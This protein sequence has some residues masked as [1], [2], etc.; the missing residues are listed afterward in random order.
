MTEKNISVTVKTKN[1]SLV[2]I[3]G[4]EPEEFNKRV[5][6]AINAQLHEFVLG[7]EE[8]IKP[9]A[10]TVVQNAFPEA[11]VVDAWV[12][13]AQPV[14]G[15]APIPPP[16]SAAPAPA[17]AGDR[18]CPHGVMT[19]RTGEGQYGPWKAWMCPTPKGTPD[20]CKAIYAK[21]GTPEFNNF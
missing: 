2:T 9:D 17:S 5:N 3:R 13:E 15:F 10:V 8:V 16:T 21:K 20:Q 7:F 6:E 11:T 19:K 18:T 1:G 4:D 12:T 14:Q